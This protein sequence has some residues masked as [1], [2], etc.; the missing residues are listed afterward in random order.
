MNC[1]EYSVL[2]EKLL[3][4][5]L[6]GE[7]EQALRRHEAGCPACA[8]QRR[9]LD[10]LQDTLSALDSEVPPMPEDFHEGWM[11]KVEEEAMEKK[12]RTEK[13]GWKTVMTRTLSVAAALGRI[14]AS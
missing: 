8:R 1:S 14:L 10:R 13:P 11:Q 7:E 9:E 5:G 12:N 4:G 6:T 2:L 3:E